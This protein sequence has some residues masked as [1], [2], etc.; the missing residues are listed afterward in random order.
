MS[1]DL[2]ASNTAPTVGEVI[3]VTA[4][5]VNIGCSGVGLP[6]YWLRWPTEPAGMFEALSPLDVMHYTGVGSDEAAFVLRALRPGSTR[7]EASVSFEVHLGYPGPAY[8][9]SAGAGL[10]VEV[11]G[12]WWQAYLPACY[13]FAGDA[14]GQWS[15][16]WSR[17]PTGR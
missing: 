5:L 17:Q 4:R 13:R 1:F 6:R 7:L 10:P 14:V 2:R 15:R 3:T 16:L 12:D 8:W 9:G 11:N